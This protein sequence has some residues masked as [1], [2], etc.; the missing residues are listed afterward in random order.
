M[1]NTTIIIYINNHYWHFVNETAVGSPEW[2]VS[3]VWAP[4]RCGYEAPKTMAAP[5]RI[6]E[7]N[8]VIR[9]PSTTSGAVIVNV[10]KRSV[11][12]DARAF[13]VNYRTNLSALFLFTAPG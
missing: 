9:H 2:G 3:L 1:Y 13:T 10:N 5:V 11:S 4:H 6:K 8:Q 12:A 7:V